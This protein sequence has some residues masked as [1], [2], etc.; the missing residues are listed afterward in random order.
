MQVSI[1]NCLYFSSFLKHVFRRSKK[2]P[3]TPDIM[4]RPGPQFGILS[5]RDTSAPRQMQD[6]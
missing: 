6:G 3:E 5:L 4:L 1:G 2:V